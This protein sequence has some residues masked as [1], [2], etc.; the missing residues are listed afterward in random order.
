MAAAL[1]A[2]GAAAKRIEPSALGAYV[3][4]RVADKASDSATAVASYTAALTMS[5][6]AAM[7]AFRAYRAGVDGG[8][9][10]LALRAAQTLERTGIVPSDARVLLYIAAVRERDWRAAA[11]RLDQIEDQDGF[12]FLAPLFRGW[13]SQATGE[14]APPSK[15]TATAYVAENDIL[16]AIARG[17]PGDSIDAVS[18]LWSTDRYRASTLR[19]AAAASLAA[20]KQRSAAIGLL[21]GDDPTVVAARA[22]LS[23]GKRLAGAVDN[24]ARGAAFI[25]ARMAGDLMNES[26][27]RSAIT[28]ARFA[29]FADPASPNARLVAATALGLARRNT[30]SLALIDSVARDPV[31]A[32]LGRSMR[33][34]RL[35][36]LGRTDEAYAEAASRAARTTNDLTRLGDI[37]ARRGRFAEAA[38]HYRRATEE[39]GIDKVGAPL[40]LALGNALD[41]GGDWR[42]ARSAFERALALSP[43]DPRLLNQLGYGMAT[44]GEEI[45]RALALLRRADAA[46]PENAAITDSI[47]WAEYKGGRIAR[48]VEILERARILDPVEP[49][50]AEHLGDVYW[51]AGRRVEAR[52][53]W[54][55]ARET[56]AEAS[57]D[58]IDGK[59]DRG[60]P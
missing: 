57:H 32:D 33:I 19:L 5:S 4:A 28:L 58:R 47:G 6:D 35:E 17:E 54:A 20:H 41:Q 40:W 31:Y 12:D 1:V 26:S 48:A 14:K 24:P 56:A 49:E 37:E 52:Y 22:A 7:V 8:D 16:L 30:E 43:D 21:A 3:R 34:D 42:G 15:T 46:Q 44:R 45:D 18:S 9:Y 11:N 25:L 50:I 2:T 60:L 10:A 59:L 39:I 55:A 23:S 51:A 53:A 29:T 36:A 27:A 13:I 38:G